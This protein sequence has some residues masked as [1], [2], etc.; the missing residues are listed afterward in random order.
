MSYITWLRQKVGRQ[1]IVLVYASVV[2]QNAEGQVLLQ[3]RADFDVW[4]LPGGIL[5]PGENILDCAHREL[6]EETGLTAGKLRLVGIYSEPCY[7]TVYPNGDAVQQ[8]TVCFQGIVK[9]GKM[10]V[11]GVESSAL[12]FFDAGHLP[13]AELPSFYVDMLKDS[14]AGGDAV[15]ATPFAGDHLIDP[16]RQVR[17]FIGRDVMVAGGA[18]AVVVDQDTI[19]AQP[20]LLVVKRT[21]DGEWSLPGGYTQ[22]GENVAH[23]VV[24]EMLEETGLHVMPERILGISSL[25][26]PWTYPNGDQTQGVA[27]VFRTHITG[28]SL[29]PDLEEISQAGWVTLREFLALEVHSDWQALYQAVAKCLQGEATGNVFVV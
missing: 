4:G 1:K 6:F 24:R 19:H 17:A 16:I 9:G 25:P 27:V 12:A 11:D 8:F 26:H 29:R 15:F 28:G 18:I 14:L 13:W 23:T 22:L 21:D 5:E 3:R 7:D 20:R 2:L 10:A